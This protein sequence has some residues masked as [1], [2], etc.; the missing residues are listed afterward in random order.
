MGKKLDSG[1]CRNDDKEMA[2]SS[3]A[4]IDSGGAKMFV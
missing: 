3:P 2:G 4:M 1:F